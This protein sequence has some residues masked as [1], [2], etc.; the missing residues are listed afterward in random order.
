M[1]KHDLLGEPGGHSACDEGVP[2]AAEERGGPRADGV[3]RGGYARISGTLCLLCH[4]A[5]HRGPGSGIGDSLNHRLII[6]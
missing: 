6:P 5:C 4:Q 2:A 1:L 3:Q